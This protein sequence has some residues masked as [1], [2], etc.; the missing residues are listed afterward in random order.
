MIAN[1]MLLCV[2]SFHRIVLHQLGLWDDFRPPTEDSLIYQIN[3]TPSNTKLF[4]NRIIRGIYSMLKNEIEHDK[5]V[6]ATNLNAFDEET[7][8]TIRAPSITSI[9]PVEIVDE[10]KSKTRLSQQQSKNLFHQKVSL[11]IVNCFQNF[12]HLNQAVQNFYSFAIGKTD[13]HKIHSGHLRI[14]NSDQSIEFEILKKPL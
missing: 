4:R 10:I 8:T 1:I 3:F 7:N 5:K 13:I 6:E 14:R 11:S 9:L 12:K 2:L